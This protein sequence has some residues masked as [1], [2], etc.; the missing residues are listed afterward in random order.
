M[1]KELDIVA[2]MKKI[3]RFEHYINASINNSKPTLEELKQ[4]ELREVSDTMVVEPEYKSGSKCSKIAPETVVPPIK[5]FEMDSKELEVN[6][7]E[8]NS[9]SPRETVE[10]DKPV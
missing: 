10:K 8:V 7:V 5:G 3:R 1:N 9:V 4:A 6:S 2:F